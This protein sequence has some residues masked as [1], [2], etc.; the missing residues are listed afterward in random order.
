MKEVSEE[1]IDKWL[2]AVRQFKTRTQAA[3]ACEQGKVFI[4]EQPAKA[5]RVV[6]IGDLVWVRR[7]GLT[8]Q[9]RVLQLTM[10]RLS[11]KLVPDYC[12]DLTPAA[13]IEAYKARIAK[14]AIY[15]A[16]GSGRPTKLER[17]ALDEFLENHPDDD[18]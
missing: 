18:F 12:E 13:E 3:T 4:N 15:R 10:N 14:A 6:R 1:R 2:W 11:A 17:R 7:T 8:R 9:I 16:P 5:S